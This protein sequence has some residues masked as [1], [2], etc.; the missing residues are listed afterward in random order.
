MVILSD[1][2][3]KK[4]F[5]KVA[6]QNPE[7]Y[8]PTTALKKNDFERRQ[9]SK[10]DRYYWT[11][12][13]STGDDVCGEPTCNAGFQVVK[14]NPSKNKLSFIDVWNKIVEILEPRGYKPIKRYPVIARWNPTTEF[15]M[16]S[17]AAFQPYVVTGEMPPPAKKLIIPQMCLRFSDIE[18]VGVTGSHCTCFVMIGQHQFVSEDEW[19]QDQAFQD[20]FDFLVDGV[21]LAKSEFKIQEDAWAGGGSFGPCMEFFSRGVELFNQV[22]TMYEQTPEGNR[23]LELKVL[24]MGMGMDRVAWFSQGTPNIYEAI[25]PKVLQKLRERTKIILDLTLYNKFSQFSAY[26]NNDEVDDMDEAWARVG[27]EMEMDPKILKET[28]VPMTAIYSIAEH[29]RALLFAISDGKLPSNV[30]GGYNL[31]VIFR[32]AM[33]FIDQFHW[34]IDMGEVCR[35]H[36]EEL[37][38]IFPEVSEHLEEVNQVLVVERQ[39]FEATKKEADKIVKRLVK[40]G[41]ITTEKLLELYDSNGIN[42]EIIQAAAKKIGTR[43]EI[44]DDFYKQVLARHEK[45]EQI[46][47]TK[48]SL[49]LDIEDLPETKSLYF[50]NYLDTENTASVLY[51]KKIS[52]DIAGENLDEDLT[53]TANKIDVWAVILNQSVAYPTSGGQLH[54]NGSIDDVPFVDVVKVGKHIVHILKEKPPFVNGDNVQVKIDLP[55]RLQLTQNHSATHIVNAAARQ[56]LGAHINQ[57]GAKKTV[58]KAHLDITHFN[59]LSDTQIDEIETRANEIVLQDIKSNNR[60]IPRA[61]AEKEYGMSLYQGGAVPGMVLRVVETPGVEVEA[62]GGTHVNR[63]GEIGIIRIMKAQKIQDGIVRLTYTAGDATERAKNQ[64]LSIKDALAEILETNPT[65][66]I[67]RSEEL[68]EKWRLLRKSLTTGKYSGYM[69]VLTSEGTDPEKSLRLLQR[70]FDCP[71]EMLETKLGKMKDEWVTMKNQ[72]DRISKLVGEENIT[73]L[74]EGATPINN[75]HFIGQYYPEIENKILTNLAKNLLKR[76]QDPALVIFLLGSSTRGL[77][78]LAMSDPR[79]KNVN[80]GEITKKFLKQVG[81]KGGGKP[82]SA[83]GVIQGYDGDASELITKFQ[84]QFGSN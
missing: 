44:P 24:A 43:V 83:Q 64:E 48:K 82:D 56:I 71:T 81:G 74:L 61:A 42:P 22:Y 9:C 34:D 52:Y 28:I 10:C 60:F 16:A 25:L 40:K 59:S 19:D 4:K 32:R 51:M 70:K 84:N 29:S 15:T 49:D 36:A 39:K 45:K 38:E 55:R 62:C 6:S 73:A 8:Y 18:N 30:G 68:L 46:H 23:P 2:A 26:L 7:K 35:W 47:A 63:T 12:I 80:I 17:I 65:N 37:L 54:D 69:M 41:D 75:L 27:R 33:G 57:A 79:L 20:I 77:N 78:F 66:L 53:E 50:A 31:R 72:V 1:K 67:K 14:N 5:K 13:S 76:A 21:G 11:W 58:D 3:Q